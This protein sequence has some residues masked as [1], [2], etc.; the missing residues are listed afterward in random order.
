MDWLQMERWSPYLVGIGIGLL[1]CL[2]LLLSDKPIG[3]SAAFSRTSGMIE[4][5]FRGKIV[6]E[7]AYFRKFSP[8]I[9]WDWRLSQEYLISRPKI[10]YSPYLHFWSALLI[11][12]VSAPFHF[13]RF[14]LF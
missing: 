9:E 3:C 12:M 4:K 5:V 1:N 7:K 2:A 11:S 14:T 13:K 6:T 10:Q 8:S